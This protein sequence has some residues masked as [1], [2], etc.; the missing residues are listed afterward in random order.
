MRIH[1]R[2]P[3]AEIFRRDPVRLRHHEIE[4]LQPTPRER[5]AAQ[6][7]QRDDHRQR[8]CDDEAKRPQAIGHRPVHRHHADHPRFAPGRHRV[9]HREHAQPQVPRD[10]KDG[11]AIPP[12]LGRH[13]HR[14]H[15]ALGER[16]K[17][18]HEFPLLIP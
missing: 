11:N 12:R 4:W 2:Q 1:H 17:P 10:V 18:S 5:V 8:P 6:H 15:P 9:G 7:Q 13:R 16:P 14:L 3:S